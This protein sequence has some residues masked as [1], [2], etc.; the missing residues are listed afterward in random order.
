MTGTTEVLEFFNVLAHG[1]GS[2]A[3]Q[4][5][6]GQQSHRLQ[7]HC[8]RDCGNNDKLYGLAIKF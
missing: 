4:V 7:Q 5:E 1:L 2:L 8:H 6:D 3:H